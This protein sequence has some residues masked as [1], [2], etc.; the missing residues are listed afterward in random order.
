M[1]SAGLGADS[2]CTSAPNRWRDRCCR[3]Q[4]PR[5]SAGPEI[6]PEFINPK[7]NDVDYASRPR[8]AFERREL[9]LDPGAFGQRS[10]PQSDMKFTK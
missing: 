1:V 3:W 10:L 8:V 6:S 5:F 2:R 9:R 4:K 7:G